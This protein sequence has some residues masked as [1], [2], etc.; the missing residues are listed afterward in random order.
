MIAFHCLLESYGSCILVYQVVWVLRVTR[1]NECIHCNVS[2]T[3]FQTVGVSNRCGAAKTR[4]S[5]PSSTL[6]LFLF[7]CNKVVTDLSLQDW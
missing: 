2:N 6:F 4:T 1:L 3:S 7:W 5:F